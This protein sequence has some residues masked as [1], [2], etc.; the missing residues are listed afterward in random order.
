MGT[1]RRTS[2][3]RHSRWLTAFATAA[4]LATAISARAEIVGQW[5]FSQGW[6]SSTGVVNGGT[7]VTGLALTYLP[8]TFIYQLPA[9]QGQPNPPPLQFATT[10]SFGIPNLGATAGVVVM[11]VPDMRGYG[12]V[13]GLM[14][15][16]PQMVNGDGSPTK[17]NRY[18]LVMDVCI[19]GATDAETP[20]YYLTMLQTR[21]GVDGA[22]LVDKRTDATG[23]ASSYGGAATPDA[24][25]RLALV[26]NLSASGAVSQYRA[27]VDG[28]LAA[29][30]VP[31]LVPPSDRNYQL[32][33]GY[34][35]NP[36]DL[37][38][39]GL[40]SIGTL[41]DSYQGLGT[42]SAFYLFN[43][44]RN[45]ATEGLLKGE[46]GTLYVA[47]LQ[48]RN[49][50]LTSQQVAALG[51]PGPGFIPVPEPAGFALAG[52][53]AAALAGRRSRRRFLAAAGAAL[54]GGR[55]AFAAGP[56]TVAEPAATPAVPAAGILADYARVAD[57]S[58]SWKRLAGG[59]FGTG[60]FLAAELVSQTWRGKPWRHQFAICLPEKLAVDRP[61]LVLWVDGGSVPDG[62]IEPPGKRLPILAAIADAAG[63]PV[64]VVRQVPNQ[65]LEGGRREDDLIAHTFEQFLLT[66]D[67]SWPLLLPMVKSVAAAL[68][69]AADLVDR[70]WNLD[71]DGCVVAGAS[72]RGWTSWLAAAVEPRI[73]GLVPMVI[74][75]LDLPRHM[76]LQVESFGAPSEAIADYVSRGLHRRLDTPR[77]EE[78]LQIVDPVRHA[79]A[80]TQPK[81]LALGANDEYWPLESLDLYRPRLRGPTWVS[82]APNAGHDIPVERVAPL[83]AALGRHVA[84]IDPLPDLE[85]TCDADSHTCALAVDPAPGAVSLWTA[86]SAS[87]DFRTATWKSRPITLADGR[88]REIVE[89]P[90][91][92]FTA[93]FVE[94]RFDRPPLP[95]FLSSGPLVVAAG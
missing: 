47:N 21:L 13:T 46:L 9:A 28:S 75:M 87:R 77:G 41:N 79:A 37:F 43:A 38:T 65:P 11:R 54:A 18:T 63:L 55:A 56:A 40:F 69:A 6:N 2:A 93:A 70:E 23:V 31:D 76:R 84:G 53:A 82:Y 25:H 34:P 60:K 90:D 48:F 3:S 83:V 67:S 45:D 8:K 88:C 74:D 12:L 86:S 26:M 80:I 42:N 24:W 68:D 15:T 20:P 44:D 10:G 92:G 59:E 16:F 27:Y 35:P 62:P 32:V 22:W 91:A 36:P 61:P 81:I 73:R 50:A 89:R 51:G 72:K 39:D 85:W 4:C 1:S 30:I 58:T 71:L 7:G 19:P 78:L 17:L 29:D 14:A 33:Y 52:A 5:D 49:E 95:V 66:G 57:P 64:A 94:C